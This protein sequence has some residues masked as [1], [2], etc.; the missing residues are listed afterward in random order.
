M[1]LVIEREDD[2]LGIEIKSGRNVSRPDTR[3]LASLAETVGRYKELKKWV[4]YTG[5]RRQLLENGVCVLPYLEA[6][7]ELGST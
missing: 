3:G 5:D 1:D 7:E 6:L 2:L 4:I